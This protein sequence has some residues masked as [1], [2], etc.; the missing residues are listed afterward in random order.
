MTFL[1]NK[2][3][4]RVKQMRGYI[5]YVFSI[6]LVSNAIQPKDRNVLATTLK[7]IDHLGTLVSYFIT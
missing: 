1:L 4:L 7:A 3:S 2:L 5:T 6:P